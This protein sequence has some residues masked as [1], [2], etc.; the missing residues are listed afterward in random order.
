MTDSKYKGISGIGYVLGKMGR[1]REALK[2]IE[3]LDLRKKEEPDTLLHMDYAI[4]YE[5]LGEWDK[6]KEYLEK[7]FKAN[8]GSLFINSNPMWKEARERPEIKELMVKY[9]LIKD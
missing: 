6:V 3:M 5:G 8:M 4:I 7:G 1:K 9:R 2:V